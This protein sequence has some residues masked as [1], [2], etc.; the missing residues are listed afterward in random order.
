MNT[1]R[2]S[3]YSPTNIASQRSCQ[4]HQR[5]NS[6]STATKPRYQLE[7]TK[8][9]TWLLTVPQGVEYAAYLM[10]LKWTFLFYSLSSAA[11]IRCVFSNSLKLC[12]RSPQHIL[13]KDTRNQDKVAS[14]GK[15][16]GDLTSIVLT[17]GCSKSRHRRVCIFTRI[18]T[19]FLTYTSA[20]R[21][22]LPAPNVPKLILRELVYTT[23]P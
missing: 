1:K 22:C 18:S 6:S 2:S 14:S 11:E 15:L 17:S 3:S 20:T 21:L 8:D 16:S 13:G 12:L 10:R 23:L 9:Y 5:A 19:R 4:P 7:A